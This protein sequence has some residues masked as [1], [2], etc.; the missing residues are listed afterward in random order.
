[1]FW[2]LVETSKKKEFKQDFIITFASVSQT[3]KYF[4]VSLVKFKICKQWRTYYTYAYILTRAEY[5]TKI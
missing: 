1:M 4:F 3:F 5:Y 2:K